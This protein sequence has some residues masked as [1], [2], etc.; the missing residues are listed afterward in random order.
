MD[1]HSY[2]RESLAPT[3]SSSV[4]S[5]AQ[6]VP[7]LNVAERGLQL[8]RIS[9]E[10]NKFMLQGHGAKFAYLVRQGVR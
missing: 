9:R 7:Q 10:A 1:F 4:A 6:R 5:A 2:S 8:G 3:I